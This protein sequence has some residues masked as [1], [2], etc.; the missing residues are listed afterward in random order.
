[1]ENVLIILFTIKEWQEE[2]CHRSSKF[3]IY[4]IHQRSLT[5]SS[6]ART[7]ER[8]AIAESKRHRERDGANLTS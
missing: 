8:A 1:M 3:H 2:R 6:N 4:K 7:A 5:L